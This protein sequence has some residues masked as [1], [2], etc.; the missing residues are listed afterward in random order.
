MKEKRTRSSS[1]VSLLILA[2]LEW[3]RVNFFEFVFNL[4][5]CSLS[6]TLLWVSDCVRVSVW[7][8]MGIISEDLICRLKSGTVF[9]FKFSRAHPITSILLCS[10]CLIATSFPMVF[11]SLIFFLT[12]FVS[13]TLFLEAILSVITRPRALE[14]ERK[15]AKASIESHEVYE[16]K[17]LVEINKHG[18][19]EVAEC[20][21]ET[22]TEIVESGHQGEEKEDKLNPNEDKLEI[23]N[24]GI[25]LMEFKLTE[26]EDEITAHKSEQ[27]EAISYISPLSVV[28]GGTRE[29]EG[30][31]HVGQPA[32]YSGLD[33]VG[34]A[35]GDE[36]PRFSLDLGSN[37][38]FSIALHSSWERFDPSSDSGSEASSENLG[39]LFDEY[40]P[41]STTDGENPNEDKNDLPVDFHF[42]GRDEN[43]FELFHEDSSDSTSEDENLIEIA[44]SEQQVLKRYG[45]ETHGLYQ[46]VTGEPNLID[47]DYSDGFLEQGSVREQILIEILSDERASF[48]EEENLIEIDLSTES[49]ANLANEQIGPADIKFDPEEASPIQIPRRQR[50]PVTDILHEPLPTDYYSFLDDRTQ[51]WRAVWPPE[52]R[53]ENS[54]LQMK[55][56]EYAGTQVSHSPLMAD[57][58]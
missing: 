13:T 25:D 32:F 20:E 46:D 39:P 52:S 37:D 35:E 54:I 43:R 9:C 12:L 28:N 17:E 10:F 57:E 23:S 34:E 40:N 18:G 41:H 2:L 51:P 24:A 1:L 53:K 31:F 22:R 33:L 6:S 16:Q 26:K 50:N 29:E 47:L 55:S 56:I 15:P 49:F 14:S 21:A 8:E 44:I 48:P 27:E 7:E 30:S 5:E 38:F 19:S 45:R 11:R 4:H 3:E 42:N 36:P 58:R